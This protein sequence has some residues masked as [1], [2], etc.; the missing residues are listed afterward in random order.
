MRSPPPTPPSGASQTLTISGASLTWTLVRRSNGQRGSSEIWRA[1]APNP[2]VNATVTSTQSRPGYHQSLTVV[3]FTGATGTGASAIANGATGAP[4]V[5]LTTTRAGS[6]VYGVG[7]DWDRAVTRVL[8]TNQVMV[9]QWVDTA[10]GD[11]FWVQA[12]STAVANANTAV[13]INDTSPTNDRWNLAAVEIV[14]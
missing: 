6:L 9:H 2:L 4:S 13:Q 8:G 7:N 10:V 14:R 5:S 1:F 3:T 12:R 11:T